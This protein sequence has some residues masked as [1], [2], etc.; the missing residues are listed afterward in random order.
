MN[1]YLDIET[2]QCEDTD[3]LAHFH[4]IAKAPAHYVDPDKIAKAKEADAKKR[5]EK[6][7]LDGTYGTIC[8]ICWAVEDADIQTVSVDTAG[9]EYSLLSKFFDVARKE[10][11]APMA[12]TRQP[13]F[14]GHNISL[15][16]RFIWKRAVILGIKPPFKIPYNAAAWNNKYTCTMYEWAGAKDFIG[17]KE[18]CRVLGIDCDGDIDGADVY[19]I[20]KAGGYDKVINHCRKDVERVREVYRRVCK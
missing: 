13:W 19:S 8:V 17:L 7:G 16:L 2:L 14:I 9:S 11:T 5:W 3:T 4:E 20:W 15:D 1:F 10:L 6:T 18:L 12:P